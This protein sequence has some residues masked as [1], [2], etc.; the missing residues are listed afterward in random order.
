MNKLKKVIFALGG[1]L[2]ITVAFIGVTAAAFT[3]QA[4][5][6]GSTFS[7]GS[8]DLKFISGLS[9]GADPSNIT[10]E[11]PG[12]SFTNIGAT[13]EGDY[14]MKIVNYGSGT[15][16]ISSHAFYETESDP[17]S[18][19]S[20]IEAAIYK[21]NDNNEDGNLDPGEEGELISKKTII[22]WKT[23]GINLGEIHA[24]EIKPL[25]IRFSTNDM[26][27]TKQ[28]KNGVFDFEFDSIQT[29]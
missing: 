16:Q 21:W 12:P 8:A 17:D 13:W 1:I 5:V 29:N 24:G 7:T 9:G 11:L 25:I 23:E 28:G 2:L 10:D 19:R 14:L 27:P 6:L 3:D 18:L 22:K 26:S 4:K 20:E 15:I